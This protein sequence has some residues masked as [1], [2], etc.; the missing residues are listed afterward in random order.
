MT[1]N[2]EILDRAIRHAVYYEQLKNSEVRAIVRF[3][4][5]KV[6]PD[7]RRT[8]NTRLARIRRYGFDKGPVTTRRYRKLL[9][10][11]QVQIQVGLRELGNYS[12]G[13]LTRLGI[14]EAEWA[15]HTLRE[16]VPLNVTFNT[17][18]VSSIRSIIN[19]RPFQGRL[20][21]DWYSTLGASTA[22]RVKD[23]INIG[24]ASGESVE[25]MTKRLLG[26][27]QGRYAG[28]GPLAGQLRRHVRTIVRTSANHVASYAR[29]E[30]YKAN[31]DVIKAVRWVSVL[32]ARTSD[33]CMSLDQKE[34]PVG[35][36]ERP[37]AH[38]QCRSTTV[39]VT[40]SWKELGVNKKDTRLGGRAYRK[41]STD[42]F[43]AV[44]AGMTGT[45]DKVVGYPEWFAKQSPAVQRQILGKSR[46]RLYARGELKFNRFFNDEG[47][48]MPLRQLARVEGL[49]YNRIL[50]IR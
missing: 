19:A 47:R 50:A 38:H 20:L 33:I 27:R 7:I 46:Q 13:R 23:Q 45:M 18:T 44:K 4:D 34:F 36:G 40:K 22:L 5:R 25:K 11:I 3:L 28:Q 39:P 1:V 2:N 43:G 15:A 32:D 29:E 12:A 16:T 26:A 6:L 41:Y 35:Q 42:R 8:L 9:R 48:L 49:D 10:E 17:P 31:K 37:P 21:A 14:T 24:L 30:T